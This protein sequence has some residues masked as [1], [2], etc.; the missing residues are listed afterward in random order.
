MENKQSRILKWSVILG[1][2][3]VL[4]LFFNYA[5][6]LVYKSPDYETYCPNEQVNLAITDKDKCVA[7]GGQWTES[8]YP[9]EVTG[10]GTVPAKTTPQIQGYCNTTYTCQKNFDTDFKVYQRNV[11]I[12]LVVLGI[13]AIG[14]GLF[15]AMSS[16]VSIG[17]SLG[18]VLSLVIAAIRYWSAAE[19]V[20]RVVILALALVALIWLGLKKFKDSDSL[21][22]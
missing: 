8:V 16:A 10:K 14:I 11:F 5:L 2:V 9:A 22:S 20:L 6:S 1:I 4:N 19:N 17:L 18:G 7:S 15:V 3:I 12:T 21:R 13:I